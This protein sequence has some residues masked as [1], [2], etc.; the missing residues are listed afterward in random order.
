MAQDALCRRNGNL[1]ILAALIVY[2]VSSTTYTTNPLAVP[3][4]SFAMTALQ[5]WETMIG[6]I[7]V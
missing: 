4:N 5:V 1:P 2:I 7:T 6:T 3:K